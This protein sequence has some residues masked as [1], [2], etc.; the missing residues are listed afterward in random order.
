L[1]VYTDRDAG[2]EIR[3]AT[4]NFITILEFIYNNKAGAQK[5]GKIFN[6]RRVAS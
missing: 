2:L 1:E 4:K 5:G 6:I 3:I